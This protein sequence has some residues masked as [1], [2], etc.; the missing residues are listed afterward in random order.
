MVV[1]KVNI[2]SVDVSTTKSAG[3]FD[4]GCLWIL[5]FSDLEATGKCKLTFGIGAVT[6][7]EGENAYVHS[8]SK[9]FSSAGAATRSKA[10]LHKQLHKQLH[11]RLRTT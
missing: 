8:Y 4:D 2:R 11:D 10:W 5:D 3:L 7:A 9:E 1:T 6:G